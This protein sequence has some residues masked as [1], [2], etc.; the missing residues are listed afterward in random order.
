MESKR[1]DN[2]M[3]SGRRACD[4]IELEECPCRYSR[5]KMQLRWIT[6]FLWIALACATFM[7]IVRVY[8]AIVAN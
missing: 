2:L 8:S 7:A 4:A 3:P 6:V 1:C 5:R